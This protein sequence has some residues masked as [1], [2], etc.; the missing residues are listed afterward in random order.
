MAASLGGSPHPA[1]T[2]PNQG[3]ENRFWAAAQKALNKIARDRK[4]LRGRSVLFVGGGTPLP[5]PRQIRRSN[6]IASSE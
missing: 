1:P 4:R 5:K 6:R 2:A 3:P